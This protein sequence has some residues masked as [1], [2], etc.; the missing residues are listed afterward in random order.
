MLR[1]VEIFFLNKKKPLYS[2]ELNTPLPKAVEINKLFTVSGKKWLSLR[3]F[4]LFAS[5][6]TFGRGALLDQ[7]IPPCVD[8]RPEMCVSYIDT[9]VN[10]R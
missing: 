7:A 10:T 9:A 5:G 8:Y 6:I 3:A 1:K 4:V 2:M